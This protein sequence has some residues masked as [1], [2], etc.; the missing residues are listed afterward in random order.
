MPSLQKEETIIGRKGALD[1]KP[2]VFLFF[3]FPWAFDCFTDTVTFTHSTVK[4]D[5]SLFTVLTFSIK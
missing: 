1:Q 5:S 2:P 3:V 4:Y